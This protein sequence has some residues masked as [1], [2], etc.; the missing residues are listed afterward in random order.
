MLSQSPYP[1][2][3]FPSSLSA[4]A[5]ALSFLEEASME[6]FRMPCS[7]EQTLLYICSITEL[8]LASH[9]GLACINYS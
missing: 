5:I 3:L 4:I 9:A 6:L 8:L 2:A 1:N 7:E